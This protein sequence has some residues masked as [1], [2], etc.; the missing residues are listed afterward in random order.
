MPTQADLDAARTYT[1][2]M[3]EA[4]F[5]ALSINRLTGPIAL[6]APLAREF[7]FLQ[8]RMLCELIA[9]GCLVAH[10]DIEETKSPQLQKS[11]NA[12]DIVKLLEKL[13]P[14]FYPSPRK[15]VFSP[16]HVHLEDYD[17]EYLTKDELLTLYGRC[18]DALHRGSLRN[19]LN[20]K[21]Q[22]PAD[23]QDIQR[24]GQKILNLLS[25]HI[26]SR[27]GGNFHL[28]AALEAAQVGGNVLV[29]VAEAPEA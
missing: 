17:G 2:I 8:L 6:S 29:S 19:L 4:K 21:S 26:I 23:F 18:G 16:G 14:N 27:V 15:P 24:W 9:L 22:P 25:F 7:C 1:S 20:R 28:V 13:H 3:E 11:Y 12:G 5:R 10:G